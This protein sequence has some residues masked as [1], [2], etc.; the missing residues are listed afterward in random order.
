MGDRVG[1]EIDVATAHVFDA[2]GRIAQ[3]GAARTH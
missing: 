1:V 2:Q 3:V